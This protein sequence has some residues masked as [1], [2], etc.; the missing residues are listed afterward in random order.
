MPQSLLNLFSSQH[1]S[2]C[3]WVVVR[4]THS[5]QF[6]KSCSH[7]FSNIRDLI[8]ANQLVPKNVT[9]HKTLNKRLNNHQYQSLIHRNPTYKPSQHIRSKPLQAQ[10][11]II[12][13]Y[14]QDLQVRLA[15]RRTRSLQNRARGSKFKAK[16][17][18]SLCRHLRTLNT[19]LMKSLSQFQSSKFRCQVKVR[20]RMQRQPITL[21]QSK[22]KSATLWQSSLLQLK[23]ASLHITHINR[24][25]TRTSRHLISW[26]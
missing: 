14:L 24:T 7:W 12:E 17:C 3:S 20:M 19:R 1:L 16:E 5:R 9:T 8:V 10:F 18:K 13:K 2:R 25:K 26:V 23:E 4:N 6:L 21:S 15:T 22:Q 11:K